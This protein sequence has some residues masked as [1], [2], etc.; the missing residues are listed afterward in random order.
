MVQDCTL[1][2]ML[3]TVLGS[4]VQLL[5][6]VL[7]SLRTGVPKGSPFKKILTRTLLSKTRN[8]GNTLDSRCSTSDQLSD[9][10]SLASTLF[11]AM[12]VAVNP[13]SHRLRS[14]AK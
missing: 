3:E 9:A 10:R 12:A 7:N 5:Q 4:L 14:Y 13:F 1:D 6:I 2:P 11:R 8:L